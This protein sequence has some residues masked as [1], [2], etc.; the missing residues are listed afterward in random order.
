MVTEVLFW[1][2]ILFVVYTYAG[3]PICLLL[4]SV[5]R[6]QDVKKAAITPRVSFI[7]AAHNE[8]SR[9]RTKLE[10]TLELDFPR[11]LFEIV[12]ASDCSTDGT[13]DIVGEYVTAP[14]PIPAA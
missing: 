2:S 10:N 7:I 13:D 14:E 12:V 1:G 8:A 5:L 6:K 3:Y 9:I 4:L 11:E